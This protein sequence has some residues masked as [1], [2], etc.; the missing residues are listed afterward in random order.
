MSDDVS[1]LF[2]S[3]SVYSIVEHHALC[4]YG[5]YTVCRRK[6]IHYIVVRALGTHSGDPQAYITVHRETIARL[7]REEKVYAM[8]FDFRALGFDSS[9]KSFVRPFAQCHQALSSE[10]EKRLVGTIMLVSNAS[11][12]SMLNSTLRV[13]YQPTR[14]LTF[15]EDMSGDA[16][17]RNIKAFVN[18]NRREIAV[19]AG[20]SSSPS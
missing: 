15:L 19:C 11:L 12:A 3:S 7:A 5:A 4:E 10:Y 17:T 13:V 18:A 8:V 6:K 14:P 9:W 1:D 16:L 2:P 20:R